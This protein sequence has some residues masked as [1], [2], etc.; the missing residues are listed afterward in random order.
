MGA[1]IGG[2]SDEQ[3]IGDAERD[4]AIS[5]L[6][7]HTSAGRLTMDEFD[8]RMTAAL[9]A[10]TQGDLTRLFTDL[11]GGAPRGG[12]LVVPSV[13]AKELVGERASSSGVEKTKIVAISAIW[14]LFFAV[15]VFGLVP[16][17]LFWI[18]MIVSGIITDDIG[19]ERKRRKELGDGS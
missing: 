17:W 1:T 4:A 3:R 12:G 8:E 5:V 6:R 13:G 2:V 9:G 16:W 19:K 7:E 10:R 18:P 11:P 15:V 14:V